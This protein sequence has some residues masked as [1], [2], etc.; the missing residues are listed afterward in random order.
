MELLYY[1]RLKVKLCDVAKS[2]VIP[3][4]RLKV[5][6]GEGW[7][8]NAFIYL[9]L[10]FLFDIYIFINFLLLKVTLYFLNIY[11][12]YFLVSL[13]PLSYIYIVS[14]DPLSYIYCFSNLFKLINYAYSEELG[15]FR[16][17]FLYYVLN[18]ILGYLY[19]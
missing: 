13:D 6:Y 16:I 11:N 4:S 17:F 15:T 3:Y 8:L 1:S 14:L 18:S 12:A 10:S 2:R 7:N 5:N 9:L 19:S